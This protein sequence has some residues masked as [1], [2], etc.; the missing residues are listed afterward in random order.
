MKFNQFLRELRA[1]Q[2]LSQVESVKRL[3][4]EHRM[5]YGLDNITFSRW[6][7]GVTTPPLR[8]QCYVISYLSSLKETME[9]LELFGYKHYSPL[10]FKHNNE[11]TRLVQNYILRM[12]NISETNH[13]IKKITN[14]DQLYAYENYH[15]KTYNE[16]LEN[17]FDI[18][19]HN[20]CYLIEY[21]D[22]EYNNILGH[23]FF[24]VSSLDKILNHFKE[25]HN[26]INSKQYKRLDLKRKSLYLISDHASNIDVENY[27]EKAIIDFITKEKI[28]YISLRPLL[29]NTAKIYI[30][31]KGIYLSKSNESD[32]GWIENEGQKHFWINI[33][34]ESVDLILMHRKKA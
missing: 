4:K 34:I 1:K 19:N 12:N 21:Y 24:T 8:K 6:E 23:S 25:N 10:V 32:I 11:E 14:T 29:N 15:L 16:A 28:S 27:K 22:D 13:S 33:I 17:Y 7:N 31:N 5:F 26:C 9:Y 2:G 18:I 20:D 30:K 3:Q